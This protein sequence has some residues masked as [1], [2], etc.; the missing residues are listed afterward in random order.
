MAS[1]YGNRPTG[2]PKPP[3]WIA[4]KANQADQELPPYQVPQDYQWGNGYSTDDLLKMFPIQDQPEPA[5]VDDEPAPQVWDEKIP[6]STPQG[7]PKPPP[8]VRST[9]PFGKDNLG[10]TL[11]DIGASFLSS[12]DFNGGLAGASRAIGSRSD[13]LRAQNA[14]QTSYGGPQGQF[15]ITT[16]ADGSRVIRKVPEFAQAIQEQEAAKRA[17]TPKDAVDQRARVVYSI[18]QLPA[19]QREAAYRD[20]MVN[21]E[22][23]GI[24]TKG[25]PMVWSDSYGAVMGGLGQ[26]VNQAENSDLRGRQFDH[27]QVVDQERLGQ[28]RQRLQQGAARVQQGAERLKRG[29]SGKGNSGFKA[30]SGFILD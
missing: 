29:G 22:Y 27:R 12:N 9:N 8:S 19:E 1:I 7:L 3:P 20:I 21:P 5:A 4:E 17:L 25:M 10:R 13:E 15:E 30:P 26:T 23:Y 11:L 2:L 14:K 16:N 6:G 18:A 28:G 24:S